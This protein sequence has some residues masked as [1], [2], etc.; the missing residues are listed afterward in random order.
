MCGVCEFYITSFD[1]EYIHW[2]TNSQN[3]TYI[4]T[5][6]MWVGLAPAHCIIIISVH[7]YLLLYRMHVADNYELTCSWTWQRQNLQRFCCP[8]NWSHWD[9]LQPQWL[10]YIFQT[11]WDC[12]PENNDGILIQES[13]VKL[14]S[15]IQSFSYIDKLHVRTFIN[16]NIHW[17]RLRC[18]LSMHP[19][20][21]NV[22]SSMSSVTSSF[23]SLTNRTQPC[24]AATSTNNTNNKKLPE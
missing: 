23:I 21:W 16:P 6:H 3:F 4:N 10:H 22:S 17:S 8:I 12:S 14:N 1:Y 9:P 20:F 19:Y 24:V 18:I 7:L 5:T 11:Q 13:F 2:S 15:S